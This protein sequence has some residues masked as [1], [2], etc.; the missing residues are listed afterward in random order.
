MLNAFSGSLKMCDFAVNV[1]KV[2]ITRKSVCCENLPGCGRTAN[3]AKT[4]IHLMY[5]RIVDKR[6]IIKD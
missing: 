5:V 2:Y 6:V 3:L 1:L 4:N